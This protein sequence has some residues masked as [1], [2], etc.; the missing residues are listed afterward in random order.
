MPSLHLGEV[1]SAGQRVTCGD[2]AYVC[3]CVCVCKA[4][5]AR[6]VLAQNTV[7]R[8]GSNKLVGG[9][10]NTV[11]GRPFEVIATIVVDAEWPMST[12]RVTDFGHLLELQRFVI[13]GVGRCFHHATS[14]GTGCRHCRFVFGS[15]GRYEG[16]SLHHPANTP[17]GFVKSTFIQ[18]VFY[19][20]CDLNVLRFAFDP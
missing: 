4:Q 20:V 7:G 18:L 6:G 5:S 13:L 12:A 8:N 3:V 2:A 11:S 17:A 14:G 19:S 16:F 1:K 15:H 10:F 9:A